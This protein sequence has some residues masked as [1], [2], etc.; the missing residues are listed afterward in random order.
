MTFTEV[1]KTLSA[2]NVNSFTEKKQGLTYLSWSYAWARVNELFEAEYTIREWENKPYLETDMGYMVETTITICGFTRKMWLPVMDAG[3][4][5]KKKE[6]YVVETYKGK[7]TVKIADIFDI[8]TAIMRCLVKN[9]AMFGLGLYIYAGEDL[10][11][12]EDEVKK[13]EPKEI[14]A[15]SKPEPKPEVKQVDGVKGSFDED[16]IDNIQKNISLYLKVLMQKNIDGYGAPQRI[17]NS[18]RKHLFTYEKNGEPFFEE[19][20]SYKIA[21]C[22]DKAR[23]IAYAEYLKAKLDK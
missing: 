8:N 6:E 2:I 17:Q 18:L 3:N 20:E 22:K 11:I 7:K 19:R 1:F 21:E 10:P 15:E 5:A 12:I 4:N 16:D 23:L 14:K 9:L 13:T